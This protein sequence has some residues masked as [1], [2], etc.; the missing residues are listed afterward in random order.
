MIRPQRVGVVAHGD[1]LARSKHPFAAACRR[2]FGDRLLEVAFTG[3]PGDGPAIAKRMA[4]AGADAI[5]AAGGDGTAWE[6]AQAIRGSTIALGIAP[7]GSGNDLAF[8]LGITDDAES[9]IPKLA[10]G[11]IESADRLDVNG[12]VILTAVVWGAAAGVGVDANRLR[13]KLPGWSR[14]PKAVKGAVYQATA[15]SRLLLDQDGIFDLEAIVDGTSHRWRAW[16]AGVGDATR[17]GG[18]FKAFPDATKRD[19]KA[20][21][22]V[23]EKT[24][25]ATRILTAALMRPGLHQARPGVHTATFRSATITTRPAQV[26]VADGEELPST[27]V[28]EC[29]V[30][31]DGLPLLLPG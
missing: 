25:Y 6:V 4:A 29:A 24:G 23:A 31:P 13:A 12:R 7:A 19:G 5:I 15:T 28:F 11:G 27:S 14:L 16:S 21:L 8:H 3:G 22:L 18:A 9:V 1:R 10:N 17:I 20:H 2:A 30:V 26:W